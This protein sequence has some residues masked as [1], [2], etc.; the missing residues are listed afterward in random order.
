M[1][2]RGEMDR[3]ERLYKI[4][5]LLNDMTVV[6]LA[7]F[8]DDLGVSLATFKRDL[9]Y[10]R[11]RLNAPFNGIVITSGRRGMSV[12]R[13]RNLCHKRPS[14][15]SA[16]ITPNPHPGSSSHQFPRTISKYS[17]Q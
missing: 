4:D 3:T 11:E 1:D 5:Q 15:T 10:I 8:L 13:E 9:E 12:G 7:T 2:G 14:R 16:L 17:A 6:P